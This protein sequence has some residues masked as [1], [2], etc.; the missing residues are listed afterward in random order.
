MAI[1]HLHAR[2]G[3]RSSG[4]SAA[5]KCAYI[6]RAGRY[7]RGSHDLAWS[8]GGY[9]P[10][11]S[12]AN[13]HL[14]WSAAD[15]HERSG[16]ILYREIQA[17]L[18]RELDAAAQRRLASRF[19][20]SVCGTERLPHTLA[21]HRGGGGN[22]HLHLMLHERG[23]DGIARPAEI[24]FK[25]AN[26]PRPELGGARK[27]RRLQSKGW[28]LKVREDWSRL[29]NEALAEV[30][31]EARID[32]RTLRAQGVDRAPVHQSRCSL[33]F[34]SPTP[35]VTPS[36]KREHWARKRR[37]RRAPGVTPSSA[38]AAA[39]RGENARREELKA[40]ARNLEAE[41]HRLETARAALNAARAVGAYLG[42]DT[43]E[44]VVAVPR[45]EHVAAASG[46]LPDCGILASSE[47]HRHPT[48]WRWLLARARRVLLAFPVPKLAA[49]LLRAR[50]VGNWEAV[51]S[52]PEIDSVRSAV[53]ETA[54]A[55]REA[56]ASPLRPDASME[57]RPP[58]DAD[59]LLARKRVAAF[60][61]ARERHEAE[62]RKRLELADRLAGKETELHNASILALAR[63]A[64]LKRQK[65]ELATALAKMD[66]Q[67]A[68]M[69]LQLESLRPGD[70]AERLFLHPT[71]SR[72]LADSMAD[73][74]HC[75]LPK[76]PELAHRLFLVDSLRHLPPSRDVGAAYAAWPSVRGTG[77]VPA[78]ARLAAEHGVRLAA[79]P[80]GAASCSQGPEI[81]RELEGTPALVPDPGTVAKLVR[82]SP[83]AA[84][85]E[86]LAAE[87]APEARQTAVDGGQPILPAPEADD[88]Q[89]WI[90][91]PP[92]FNF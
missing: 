59:I 30:G 45:P 24:W 14:Y 39:A 67:L 8:S 48:V 15:R 56:K 92:G 10:D 90:P 76:A 25:R 66:S 26:G 91:R 46:K 34:E 5:A 35:D 81:A 33:V 1:Y 17:S 51:V 22:P 86:R 11:W 82:E 36:S 20:A 40:E 47:S 31:L 80:V 12:A 38:L 41:L 53:A 71:S 74:G 9:M 83:L 32:H 50:P 73:S 28:L 84:H 23:N 70:A 3:S 27:T 4:K 19:A 87:E 78:L 21:V 43:P 72:R 75:L 62:I 13:P 52:G 69:Q 89:D 18:P 65:S 54:V 79:V 85:F 7:A 37:R 44:D 42:P 63:G 88:H 2:Y 61:K 6:L 49:T 16:A 68:G 57:L 60:R 29:A 55:V 77:L 58:T 64:A